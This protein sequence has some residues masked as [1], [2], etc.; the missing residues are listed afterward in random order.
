MKILLVIMLVLSSVYGHIK[1]A[2]HGP[3]SVMGDHTHDKG[4]WM[5]SY[6]FMYMPMDS[7]VSA[8]KAS[9]G[10]YMMRPDNMTMD[11]N[12][13]GLMF[14]P[15]NR[16]TLTMMQSRTVKTMD[17]VNVMTGVK[18]KMTVEGVSDLHLGSLYRWVHSDAHKVHSHFGV[19]IPM[20]AIDAKKNGTQMGYPMQLGSG[21]VDLTLGVT[22]IYKAGH[23]T[24]GTQAL[25][26][27]RLGEND[28]N[29]KLG[30]IY[31]VTSWYARPVSK[32]MSAS[33]RS[34]LKAWERIKG[35]DD[36]LTTTMSPTNDTDNTGG[37]QADIA[38]GLNY[39]L[40]G[41]PKHNQRLSAEFSI[42]LYQDLNGLQLEQDWTLTLGWQF[43]I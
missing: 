38:V 30:N 36:N 22:D 15:T 10:G 2:D 9:A 31:Q 21:T 14:A 37:I 29:Y 41:N 40:F 20:G 5:T 1:P 25:G 35:E 3:I 12:M 39:V 24:F 18:T 19:S 4:E 11:M 33:I 17:M 42:P 13:M 8:T 28:R 6:R 26:T 43:L 32:K 23:H 16:L 34:T 27:F 7:G